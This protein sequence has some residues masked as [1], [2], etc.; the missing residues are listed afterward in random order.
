MPTLLGEIISTKRR[1][2]DLYQR[3]AKPYVQIPTLTKGRRPDLYQR[4]AKPYVSAPSIIQGPEARPIT[5]SCAT[6]CTYAMPPRLAT[7]IPHSIPQ[8][9][10]L[11]L[12]PITLQKRPQ[13]LLKSLLRMVRLLRIDIPNQPLQISR[14]NGKR[15]ISALPRKLRQLRRLPLQP[16]GRRRLHLR[17]EPRNIGL[18]IQP[19]RQMNMV[20]HPADAKTLTAILTDNRR[21]ISKERRTYILVQH[22]HPILRAEHHMH[23]QKTQRSRHSAE[24]T[25]HLSLSK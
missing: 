2:R 16:L 11:T 15:A 3:R 24:Y 8:I 25:S 1:R 18:T 23:E 19:D 10:L 5:A 17:H 20:G 7:S 12:N 13:L 14:P 22:H 9:P 21:Q 4:R 6:P